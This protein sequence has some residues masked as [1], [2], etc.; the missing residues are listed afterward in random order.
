MDFREMQDRFNAG[1]RMV[2]EDRI[3]VGGLFRTVLTVN[4]G[5]KFKDGRTSKPKRL[6]IVGIDK[7]NK[8]CYG[9]VLVNTEMSPMA[10][11]SPLFFATQYCLKQEDYPEY[12]DYDSYVDCGV[13]FAISFDTLKSGEYFG[14]LN[15][16]DIEAIFNILE[17]T[18]A[19]S[20]KD[21]KRFNIRRR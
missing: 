17:T 4:D 2:T 6:V 19:I 12:L 15:S 14:T 5:L 9:T 20:T 11:V 18:K 16:D 1:K 3:V 10:K 13:L 21:K 7:T 8:T